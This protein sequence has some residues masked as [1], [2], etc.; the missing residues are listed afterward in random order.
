MFNWTQKTHITLLNIF[1]KFFAAL[2][3]AHNMARVCH[4]WLL[5]RLMSVRI[6]GFHI[7]RNFYGCICLFVFYCINTLFNVFFVCLKKF[8]SAK[9]N[10]ACVC[11][12]C[13]KNRTYF[14]F[15]LIVCVCVSDIHCGHMFA[16][17]TQISKP[18]GLFPIF[19]NF[20]QMLNL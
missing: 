3:F 9:T 18:C 1:F 11:C 12:G 19:F 4:R 5:H 7:V 10:T 17:A 20:L 2:I 13:H 6:F 14:L 8:S 16:A 15:G